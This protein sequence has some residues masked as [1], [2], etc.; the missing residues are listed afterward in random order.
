MAMNEMTIRYNTGGR[1]EPGI[2]E[3]T[4]SPEMEV[5]FQEHLEIEMM[6]GYREELEDKTIFYRLHVDPEKAR[7]IAV[8]LMRAIV[9]HPDSSNETL[10]N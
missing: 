8:A 5:V 4:L 6:Q 3:M 10:N 9:N 2:V 7:M 1:L